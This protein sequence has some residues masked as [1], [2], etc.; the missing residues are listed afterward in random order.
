M[1]PLLVLMFNPPPV[2]YPFPATACH[3]VGKV[4][5]SIYNQN[6][7]G[8]DLDVSMPWDTVA[9]IHQVG[10]AGFRTLYFFSDDGCYLGWSEMTVGQ[11]TEL[12]GTEV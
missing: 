7:S 8:A 4:I 10:D 6:L 11:F 9:V 12:M 1:I 2:F 3:D 5:T